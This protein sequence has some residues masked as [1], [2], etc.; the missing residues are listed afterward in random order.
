MYNFKLMLLHNESILDYIY[1]PKI[2]ASDD[3]AS[4]EHRK[5]DF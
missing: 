2:P 1:W 4:W 5:S 3:E